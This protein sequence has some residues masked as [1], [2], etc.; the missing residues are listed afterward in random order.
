M[1]PHSQGMDHVP[2]SKVMMGICPLWFTDTPDLVHSITLQHDCDIK[3]GKGSMHNSPPFKTFLKYWN[4]TW[5][6]KLFN[7]IFHYHINVI[8]AERI[9]IWKLSTPRGELQPK[10][11]DISNELCFALTW[12]LYTQA[13]LYRADSEY[14]I[15]KHFHLWERSASHYFQP[16]HCH[17]APVQQPNTVLLMIQILPQR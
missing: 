7:Q 8:S 9:P 2:E 10:V 17:Y 12:G 1:S 16:T 13:K 14:K 11:P 3:D 4:W 15:P 6:K 5:H